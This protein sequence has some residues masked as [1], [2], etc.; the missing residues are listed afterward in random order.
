MD[1]VILQDTDIV[2]IRELVSKSFFDFGVKDC[3]PIA[4]DIRTLIER[5]GIVLCEYPFGNDNSSNIDGT[6]TIF[7]FLDSFI[8]FMG[9]N[10]SIP[11][12]KQVFTMAH[13]LYH[14]L[15]RTGL[16]FSSDKD[17]EDKLVEKK[18]DRFAAEL[19]LPVNSLKNSV[20]EEFGKTLDGES[21]LRVLRF[22]IGLQ[23]EWWLPY[24]SVVLRLN[25]EGYLND[26]FAYFLEL[27]TDEGSLYSTVFDAVDKERH[28]FLNK[29]TKKI[30]ISSFAMEMIIK[31]Y[32]DGLMTDDEF[33]EV[34]RC[35]DKNP[36][37]YGFDLSV[38]CDDDD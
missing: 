19:L 1:E 21:D 35:F 33:F 22:I 14:Y 38:D 23:C 28:R 6:L 11:Y 36:S 12:D 25:E 8:T 37:D 31:N 18:A 29:V 15:T 16:A 30:G 5:K 24:R 2:E 7:K 17:Q 4:N 27:N 9:I 34:L 13:E 3:V 10:T 20:I 26:R 32:E